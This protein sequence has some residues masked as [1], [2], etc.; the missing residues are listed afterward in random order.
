MTEKRSMI[1]I[2]ATREA[3]DQDI[4]NEL[5]WIRRQYNISE[6]LTKIQTNEAMK[7]FMKTGK[8]EYEVEQFVVR[9]AIKTNSN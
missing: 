1:D 2:K 4:I 5:E 8:V 6:A 3:N 7:N 9:E